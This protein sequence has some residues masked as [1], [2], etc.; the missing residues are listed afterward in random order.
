M[1]ADGCKGFED[2][3]EPDER[4]GILRYNASSTDV[5]TTFR[6]DYSLAC[7]DENYAKLE[8][9]LEWDI[10]KVNLSEGPF[11]I[12]LQSSAG[13]PASGDNFAFWSFGA[14]PLW[15]NFSNPTIMNLDN[16]TWNPDYVIVS[17]NTTDNDPNDPERWVYIV[18]TAPPPSS[19]DGNKIFVSA[20]HP[21]SS[22][23]AFQEI[24]EGIGLTF[25]SY[26]FMDMTLPSLLRVTT[27]Q[28]CNRGM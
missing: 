27:P 8:P 19:L 10:P 11:D 15:L 23:D 24:P 9:I 18:I 21:V 26:I 20:A 12:G 25:H 7:R 28:T 14:N 6:D 22:K 3:N 13:R 17:D 1:A 2:G 16:T 4:Q 5:P